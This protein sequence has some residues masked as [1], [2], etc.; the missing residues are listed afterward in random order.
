MLI[1][2]A[3]GEFIGISGIIFRCD[4]EGIL[5]G[6][7][8]LQQKLNF[9]AGI[10]SH[11]LSA[12]GLV[13]AD[14]SDPGIFHILTGQVHH[15]GEYPVCQLV[16]V[17]GLCGLTLLIF[18]GNHLGAGLSVLPNGILHLQRYIADIPQAHAEGNLFSVYQGIDGNGVC[19]GGLSCRHRDRKRS[20]CGIFQCA[21][22]CT[23]RLI[24]SAEDPAGT[25]AGTG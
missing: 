16:I 24:G 1:G 6:L 2:N 21:V 8:V 19:I 25:G 23:L 12:S 22:S 18:A 20:A 9:I 5:S 3:D 10:Q 17:N 4:L 14:R 7:S 13:A 15:I 11:R